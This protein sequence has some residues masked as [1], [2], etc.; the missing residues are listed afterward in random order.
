MRDSQHSSKNH[1]QASASSTVQASDHVHGFQVEM[2]RRDTDL[3]MVT[4]ECRRTKDQLVSY[5]QVMER[6]QEH[7]ERLLTENFNLQT[8]LYT[9]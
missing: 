9:P 8:Q 3:V 2:E 4:D 5:K 7:I 1:R 6:Q